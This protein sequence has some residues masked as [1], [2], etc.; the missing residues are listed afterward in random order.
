MN[1]CIF[2]KACSALSAILTAGYLFSPLP[3]SGAQ[4]AGLAYDE[5]TKVILGTAAP[6]PGTFSA[7]FDAAVN[8]QR[9]AA[10]SGTHRGLFG[11]IMNAMDTAKNA[12][13]VLKNGSASSDYFLGGWERTDDVGAQTAIV[14]KPQQ[15][16]I[17]YLNI[18][19]KTYRVLDTN[20]PASGGTPPPVAMERARN[21][22]GPPQPGSGNSISRCRAPH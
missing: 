15:H 8:A 20:V 11:S 21:A 12:M 22:A 1:L 5:V 4:P 19:K 14:N 13:S 2:H 17:V 16:Q 7:D 6:D 3:A 10:S 18:A 9:S